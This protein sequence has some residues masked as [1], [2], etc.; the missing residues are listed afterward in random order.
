MSS[1]VNGYVV[2]WTQSLPVGVK[3]DRAREILRLGL[4]FS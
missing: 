1:E 4:S 3:R 2:D